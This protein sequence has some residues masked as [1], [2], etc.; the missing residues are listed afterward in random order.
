M[1]FIDAGLIEALTN[2][3]SSSEIDVDRIKVTMLLAELLY[4]SNMLLPPSL[5][6]RIQ[7]TPVL[8][9]KAVSF[10][11]DAELRSRASTMVT[12]LHKYTTLKA[13]HQEVGSGIPRKIRDFRLARIDEVRRKIDWDMDDQTLQTMIRQTQVTQLGTKDWSRWKW[14]S[15]VE[16]LDGPLRNPALLSTSFLKSGST[17]ASTLQKFFKR[18]LSFLRP[19]KKLFSELSWQYE[20]MI[21]VRAGT[22]LL[23]LLPETDG[24]RD[25]LLQHAFLKNL[26]E[27]LAAEVLKKE[28]GVPVASGTSSG[29]S[30][31]RDA[32]A[33]VVTTAAAGSGV[34]AG[35]FWSHER[36]LRTMA[37][38]YF[39]LLG[40]L[41]RSAAGLNI[42]NNFGIM[43]RLRSLCDKSNRDDLVHLILTSLDY[44]QKSECIS[45]L[46]VGLTNP[47]SPVV[48]YL[49]TRHMRHLLRQ[50]TA[51][52][53]NW[54][55]E[56]LHERVTLPDSEPKVRNLALQILDEACDDEQSMLRLISNKAMLYNEQLGGAGRA[57]QI[58][59]LSL[60]QGFQYLHGAPHVKRSAWRVS[61]SDAWVF[62]E[63]GWIHT[64]LEKWLAAENAAYV[65]SVEKKISG[66]L[67]RPLNRRVTGS[68]GPSFLSTYNTDDEVFVVPHFFGELAKTQDGCKFIKRANVVPKFVKLLTKNPGVG[69]TAS[70]LDRRAAIWALGHITCS[71]TGFELLEPQNVVQ[72]LVDLA[73]NAQS[74]SIRGT[75]IYVLGMISGTPQ[76]RQRLEALGWECPVDISG[77]CGKLALP[78]CGLTSKMF[79]VDADD[80]KPVRFTAAF[81]RV[82]WALPDKGPAASIPRKSFP[83]A[84]DGAGKE[85]LGGDLRHEI[86]TNVG[87]LSNHVS[88]EPAQR[89]LRRLKAKNPD[90][91]CDPLLVFEVYKILEHLTFRLKQRRFIGELFDDVAWT[92][93]AFATIESVFPSALNSS[94][95][96]R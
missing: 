83:A 42:L 17:L 31:A 14:D 21:Y 5:C 53:E 65:E 38:E 81:G 12:N 89:T 48:R 84:A 71:P 74:L 33:N 27:V 66:V 3:G 10:R 39:P 70:S 58:R 4:L 32:S 88:A 44:D 37:R 15:I 76:V 8:V 68:D 85:E 16:L 93:E 96:Y 61:D 63:I 57:L 41:T 34:V 62:T 19:S 73:E 29:S 55:I 59:F 46:Q 11:L 86:L 77:N 45:I 36:M 24:G 35:F 72:I 92:E 28:G 6:A 9:K 51:D 49:A 1:T 78:I 26:S 90:A 82:M 50:R 75:A 23:E 69:Q 87:N 56:F 54:G 79:H 60:P 64:E 18:L 67:N 91:F 22:A 20:N 52:F 47:K 94:S 43:T 40:V 95:L 13:S 25:F 30:S 2:L 80:V 7:Q